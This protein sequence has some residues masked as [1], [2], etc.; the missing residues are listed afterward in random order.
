MTVSHR[1]LLGSAGIAVLVALA[2][3]PVHATNNQ[4][5]AQ[6]MQLQQ[7]GF[8][9]DEIADAFGMSVGAVHQLCNAPEAPRSRVVPNGRV[10]VGPAGPAPF[11]AAGP[12]PIGAAGPAP[13]GAAGP[14]PIGAAGKAPMGAAG[15]STVGSGTT[16][17]TTKRAR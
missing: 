8:S 10:A 6:A 9:V 14:A 2:S 12:A 1:R 11:G 16:S 17:T 7:Q 3:D 4:G 15:G 5:C 13:M